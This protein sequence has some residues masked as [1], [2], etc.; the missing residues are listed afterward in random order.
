M[1]QGFS[2]TE[3]HIEKLYEHFIWTEKEQL[4]FNRTV[5]W[6][7]GFIEQDGWKIRVSYYY[8]TEKHY[9]CIVSA[10]KNGVTRKN[11]FAISRGCGAVENNMKNLANNVNRIISE[12]ERGAPGITY[13][14]LSNM[15]WSLRNHEGVTV[16]ASDYISVSSLKKKCDIKF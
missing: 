5:P 3:Y 16:R 7:V 13:K 10:T 2:L 11:I 12:F 9:H 4:K 15:L 1:G 6:P 14:E 8:H